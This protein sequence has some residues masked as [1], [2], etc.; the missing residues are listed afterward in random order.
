MR[1]AITAV[2]A[3]SLLASPLQAQL[4][5]PGTV[6]RTLM[7]IDFVNSA[8]FGW[9]QKSVRAGRVLDSM[10]EPSAWMLTGTGTL[11]FPPASSLGDMRSLRVDMQL[12][13]DAPA[14]NRARLPSI[15][16]QRAFPDEDRLMEDLLPDT[17]APASRPLGFALSTSTAANGEI[18]IRLTAQGTGAHAYRLRTDNI[19]VAPASHQRR[20]R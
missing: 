9:L 8:E 20:A 15:N 12:F 18:T 4:R 7:P 13:R 1:L 6:P 5:L 14:P 17:Q 19:S 3:A 10:T 16:L 2:A 11:T